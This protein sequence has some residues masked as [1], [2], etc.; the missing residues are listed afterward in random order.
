MVSQKKIDV[1]E[2]KSKGRNVKNIA[3]LKTL[4]KKKKNLSLSNLSSEFRLVIEFNCTGMTFTF[5]TDVFAT[6]FLGR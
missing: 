5:G 4:M 6:Y 1:F 3:A 2:K